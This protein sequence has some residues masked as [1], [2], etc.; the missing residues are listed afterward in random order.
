M[1]AIG[2]ASSCA[3]VARIS[4]FESGMPMTDPENAHSSSVQ[5]MAE[6]IRELRND[7]R[8]LRKEVSENVLATNATIAKL[9]NPNWIVICSFAALTLSGMEAIWSQIVPREVIINRNAV[10]D[11]AIALLRADATREMTDQKAS[12]VQWTTEA[13]AKLLDF[14][15]RLSKK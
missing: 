9:R 7:I 5:N 3:R 1:R 14:D 12:I 4:D 13:N 2:R 6:D 8:E 11:A 10:V 15:K